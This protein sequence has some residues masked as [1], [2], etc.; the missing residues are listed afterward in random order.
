[1]E[2]ELPEFRGDNPADVVLNLYK[3]LGWDGETSIDP[4]G[5]VMNKNDWF[6]L[7]DKIRSTVPEEEVMNVGFL[8][9]NKGPSVSDI[10]PE[11]KVLIRRQ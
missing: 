1:M 7:F 10:V 9:I 8:L 3:D 6:R 2:V 5:I 11:G 4:M